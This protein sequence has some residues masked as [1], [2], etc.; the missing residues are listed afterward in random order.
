MKTILVI[1][2]EVPISKVLNAYLVKAGFLVE[3]AFTGE[4]GLVK[5]STKHPDL[6]LLDVM[7]PDQEGWDVLKAIRKTNTCP[8]IMLT[9]LGEQEHKLEGLNGGA[10]D[11]ITKPFMGEEVVAR[12]KAVLRRSA[13][14]L[15]EE[16]SKTYGSLRIDFDAYNVYLNAEHVELI[17]KDL[18]LLLFLAEHPNRFYTREQLIDHVWGMNYFGSDRAVD[19]AI[20]RIRKALK[21]W[22][23]TEGEIKTLRG[24]GYQFYVHS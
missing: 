24:V 19:L 2:D 15:Q 6:I 3:Q 23:T 13:M 18:S 5:F 10:D 8:V 22:P 17:P 16:H 4:E 21:L 12:I 14:V 1:E 7:L 11:Y 20:K 9:A